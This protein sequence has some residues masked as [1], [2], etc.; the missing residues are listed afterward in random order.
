MRE[1]TVDVLEKHQG[2]HATR[3]QVL[4]NGQVVVVAPLARARTTMV[5]CVRPSE[6]RVHA[7][8]MQ[9]VSGSRIEEEQS[10]REKS[11]RGKKVVSGQDASKRVIKTH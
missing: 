6:S 5:G 8:E 7:M 4:A 2:R 9:T 10:V 1:A 3:H 11:V